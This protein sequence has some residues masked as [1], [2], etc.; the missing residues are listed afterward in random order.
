MNKDFEL[1][2]EWQKTSVYMRYLVVLIA[3]IYLIFFKAVNYKGIIITASLCLIYNS[4]FLFV[5]LKEKYE[6]WMNHLILFLDILTISLGIFFT[7]GIKSPLHYL[8]FISLADATIFLR[9]R[10]VFSVLG[11]VV[12]G[13]SIACFNDLLYPFTWID[14]GE[15]VIFFSLFSSASSITA[16]LGQKRF[17]E[18]EK[19]TEKEKKFSLRLKLLWEVASQIMRIEESEKLFKKIT[20]TVHKTL[21]YPYV[22]IMIYDEEKNALVFN[23]GSGEWE[24]FTP[25][26][27][28]QEVS[29]GLIGKC[30][31][32]GETLLVNDVLKDPD[33]IAPY[34][35]KTRA[36]ID[37]PIRTETEI[38]G[39]LNIQSA[40][41]NDFDE[42]DVI[43]LETLGD[44]IGII[45]E[46]DSL[47]K[48]L[49]NA[50]EEI[51]KAQEKTILM[52]KLQLIDEISAEVAHN[53]HNI[54][55]VIEGR[56][57]F[58]EL[59]NPP[60]ELVK[61]IEEI[62]KAVG[63][64]IKIVENFYR[65]I[66][67]SREI[68]KQVETSEIIEDSLS[69]CLNYLK[70]KGFQPNVE[71][72]K[73][74]SHKN[75]V[76]GNKELLK[77]AFFNVILNSIEAMKDGGVLTIETKDVEKYVEIR[78]K[79]TGEGMGEDTK[80]RIFQPFFSTKKQKKEFFGLYTTY[81]IISFHKGEIDIV[82]GKGKGTIVIIRLPS[83]PP[84]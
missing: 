10:Q 41:K 66:E 24:G 81:R 11:L 8:Y 15:R 47:Y 63:S 62:K 74:Y 38:L 23:A 76:H 40:R 56:L 25:P 37:A 45:I 42:G 65:A 6:D 57:E 59:K 18:R 3:F 32:T 55:S 27:Y 29:A 12:V 30:F 36:E 17:E 44:I 48:E 58:L 43:L 5:L 31:R 50:Y 13:Y 35:I 72:E 33:Y 61:D 83:L 1:I 22:S 19:A 7:G 39:V 78:I 2:R 84:S 28:S 4:W 51:Q 70:E 46:N 71:I 34:L 80:K 64:G 9:P 14:L 69:N 53:F 20:D 26:G 73:I 49:K 77:E 68:F 67:E 16:S 54:F 82:S 75:I 21:G 60:S 52:E 79:D